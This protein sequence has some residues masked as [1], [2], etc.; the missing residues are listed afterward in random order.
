MP[1]LRSRVEL[2]SAACFVLFAVLAFTVSP[3]AAAPVFVLALLL[4]LRARAVVRERD[5]RERRRQG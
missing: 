3:V 2:A 4:S 1:F 5:A